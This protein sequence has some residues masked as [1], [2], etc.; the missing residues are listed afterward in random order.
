M[1]SYIF[2]DLLNRAPAE[3]RNNA[4][5]ARD[6]LRTNL[7]R[8]ISPGRLLRPDPDNKTRLSARPNPGTLNM[9]IYE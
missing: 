7:D 2:T 3:I 6:W 1:A 4:A 5:D 9:F 8:S